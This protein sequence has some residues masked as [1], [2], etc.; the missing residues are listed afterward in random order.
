MQTFFGTDTHSSLQGK[1]NKNLANVFFFIWTEKAS[2]IWL[3]ISIYYMAGSVSWQD[4]S[5]CVL[6]LA[7]HTGKMGLPCLLGIAYSPL[8]MTLSKQ[9]GH[10]NK[11]FTDWALFVCLFGLGDYVH[12][13]A[14]KELG[15]Y[16]ATSTSCFF[17][18]TTLVKY[19]FCLTVLRSS[20]QSSKPAKL[21]VTP[22]TATL[23]KSQKNKTKKKPME[24]KPSKQTS[25]VK[26][27]SPT[28]STPSTQVCVMYHH[29]FLG[30]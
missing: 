1:E 5:N 2:F 28:P 8:L 15:Q 11:S 13:Y 16:C 27:A 20:N 25:P 14:Q 4:E 3:I 17:I 22:S 18:K 21:P 24:K 30:V 29:Y 26:N 12:K 10:N 7:T 19:I 9:R 6:W 23:T